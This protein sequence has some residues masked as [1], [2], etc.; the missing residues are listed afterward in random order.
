MNYPRY[1]Q[2]GV[3]PPVIKY[4]MLINAAV[5]L[6]EISLPA[7]VSNQ[8]VNFF[9][10]HYWGSEL[11]RP[12]QLITH[13]F[14]HGSWTHLFMN[15]FT[16][17]VFGS[18]L[19][20]YWGPKRFLNFYLICG[21]GAALCHLGVLT[22]ENVELSKHISEF[23]NEP[24]SDAFMKIYRDYDLNSGSFAVTQ[25]VNAVMDYP[26]DPTVMENAK[27]FL[28]HFQEE[29]RNMATLGASGAV[30]G[31]LFAFGYLFPNTYFYLFLLP[32]QIKAKYIVGTMIIM[33]ILAGFRNVAGDNVAHFA[34]LGGV[35]FSYILLKTWNR[36]NRKDFY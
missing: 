23:M 34:H 22:Y 14:M 13:L 26:N 35:L 6:V 36:N 1:G 28:Q 9:A 16:L 29:Y 30:Y 21:I 18:K 2:F 4:L 11:F 32:F 24:G 20:I 7:E 19:E 31:I 15:M 12:H 17:W 27:I 25:L 10:L 8:M 5:F 3:L 33:E